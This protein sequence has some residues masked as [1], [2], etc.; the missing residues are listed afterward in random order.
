MA[1]SL[2]SLM[3]I[4][5]PH[6]VPQYR[7]TPFFHSAGSTP[8]TS[9]NVSPALRHPEMLPILAAAVDA[10]TILRKDLLDNSSSAMKQFLS[11]FICVK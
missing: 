9:T 7:Q 2:P 10:P 5:T 8:S 3:P 11:F 4:S 1:T 6:P